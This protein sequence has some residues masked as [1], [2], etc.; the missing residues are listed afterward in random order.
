MDLPV[1]EFIIDDDDEIAG[2][3]AVSIVNNPAIELPALFFSKDSQANFQIENKEERII[4][5]PIMVADKP[6]FRNAIEQAGIPDH[7]V[8]FTAKTIK[9]M[10]Q[11]YFKD[12][13]QSNSNLEHNDLHT[14]EGVTMYE[15]YQINRERGINPPKGYA[16]IADGSWF[17]SFK[18]FNEEVWD[19]IR[20]GD[21]TGFSIEVTPSVYK[22]VDN[23]QP[24]TNLEEEFIEYTNKLVDLISKPTD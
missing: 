8:V 21:F 22:E 4:T 23:Y 18:V 19:T 1:Y 6:I 24:V 13:Y 15:S 20:E 14:L 3:S 12:G 5:G 2:V 7:Y 11:K 9:T 16:S 10:M 17:G